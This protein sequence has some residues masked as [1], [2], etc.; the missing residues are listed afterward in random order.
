MNLF[1]YSKKMLFELF[2]TSFRV[3]SQSTR[4]SISF[5]VTLKSVKKIFKNHI[6]RIL[7]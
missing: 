7:E 3:T 4:S 6:F 2:P 1:Q 5:E